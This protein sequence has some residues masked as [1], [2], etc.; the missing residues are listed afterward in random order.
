MNF[1]MQGQPSIRA[2]AKIPTGVAFV[3]DKSLPFQAGPDFDHLYDLPQREF[4]DYGFGITPKTGLLNMPLSTQ[5]SDD[6]TL[7]VQNTN[8]SPVTIA[9]WIVDVDIGEAA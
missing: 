4:E 9:S 2:H 3:V 7:C 1:N 8:P 5:I 6:A